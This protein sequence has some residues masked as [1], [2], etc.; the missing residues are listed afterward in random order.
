MERSWLVVIALASACG[1]TPHV[2]APGETSLG[3]IQIRGNR[4]IASEA[5]EPALALHETVGESAAI[6]PYL[7][8]VDTDRIRA[9]YVKRG[10]FAVRV[11]PSVEPGG[12][13]S[14]LVV[15]TVIEGQ[16]A[17]VRVEIAGLPP[18]V[19]AAAA[20]ALVEL[21]DGEGF[22]YDAYNA[23]KRPLTELVQNAGYARAEVRG[24]ASGDPATGLAVVRYDI[25]PGALC[26][27]G[28]VRLPVGGDAG[29][30]AAVRA[31]L[32]FA[33]GD[34]YSASAIAASQTAI[35]QLG[36]FSA[37]KLDPVLDG[38]RAAPAAPGDAAPQVIDVAAELVE[39]TRHELHAGFGFGYDPVNYEARVRG[40]GSL[41]P[42]AAP[43]VTLAVE[44]RVALTIEHELDENKLEPKLRILGSL[45]RMDLFVPQ[46]RGEAEGGLDY[47]TI[48]AYTWAGAHI[49]L[50]LGS[51]L[52]PSW[53]Q[54]RIGWLLEA[55]TFSGFA[56]ELSDPTDGSQ[57]PGPAQARRALGLDG[58]QRLGAYQASLVADLRDDPIEPHLG[59]YF[60]VNAS[61]GT[62]WAG[63]DLRYLQ[64]TPE[65]RGYVPLGGAV[66]AARARLGQILGDVPVT[67]RYYSGGSSGQR[68]FSERQL[69]PRVMAGAPG[70]ADTGPSATVIGG[71][72]LIETSVELRRQLLSLGGNPLGA[73]LFLDGADVTCRPDAV[74]PRHLQ[75]ATGVGLWGKIAGLK[76]RTD[77]GYRLDRKG[78][79]ELSGG[80]GA[81]GDFAWN[82]GIGEA[83]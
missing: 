6:D 5:L 39:A 51:P 60:T 69:A 58:A 11:T 49:R 67:E 52:G 54:A 47:Q 18:E 14:Q 36:R 15:F 29:L 27:F 81:F 13:R 79:G 7:L 17:A 8:T 3:G 41:V 40:G 53:L 34:R 70:C 4:A 56:S 68:G 21:R 16:R 45:Q 32:T 82:I 83:Y 74:D 73:N 48:E 1:G 38:G 10:Y 78:K 72:G 37:V 65:L 9:A 55:L 57:D 30:A 66:L 61:G 75:W 63:G 28:E 80:T 64:V 76:F 25:D 59:G 12:G 26:R 43:L 20:R 62:R 33:P 24:S 71:A 44:S 35:F 50:G 46:L 23:A 77:F 2:L 19:P 22:D 31:R 42:A